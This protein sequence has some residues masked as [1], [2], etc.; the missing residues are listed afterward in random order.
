MKVLFKLN[1]Y[2]R[3]AII[4]C[5]SSLV[6][7]A[8]LYGVSWSPG[9]T[10]HA[11]LPAKVP[12][13]THHLTVTLATL[14]DAA[15]PRRP[16]STAIEKA[17]VTEIADLAA[18]AKTAAED[19]P[20]LTDTVVSTALDTRYFKPA[21]LDQHPAIIRDIPDNPTE[22]LQYPQG[23]EI[24]LRL[25]IDETGKVVNVDTLASNLPQ[26]FIDSA[27]ASFLQASFSPG[28]KYGNAVASVMD[29]AMSYAPMA[30][31]P[32]PAF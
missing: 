14:P 2:T 32:T 28:R 13:G 30:L 15:A 24:L 31:R 10:N 12:D 16:D 7:L 23:G 5:I 8:I 1:G 22:L 3:L 20:S 17:A 26:A 6:H 27:R 18:G 25:W 19:R 4:F 29:I 9:G 11:I 21:E